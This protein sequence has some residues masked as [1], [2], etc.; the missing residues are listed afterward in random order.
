MIHKTEAD[1][2]SFMNTLDLT[3]TPFSRRGSW[4]SLSCP[5][6][7]EFQPL[8]EGLYFRTH[9]SRP[10]VNR[11]LFKLELFE[12]NQVI[13]F[14]CE[15][16]PACVSLRDAEGR[17]RL[18]LVFEHPDTLR[19]QGDCGV[20]FLSATS[21][22]SARVNAAHFS[23]WEETDTRVTVNARPSLRKYGFEVLSGSMELDAPWNGELVEKADVIFR[24]DNSGQLDAAIDEYWST[25]VVPERKPFET[26]LQDIETGFTA[27]AEGF[28]EVPEE[29]AD[30]AA[31]AQYVL[32]SCTMGAS[33]FLKREAIYM[34]LNWMDQIWSWDNCF[35]LCGVAPSDPDL[36]F[37][38]LMTMADQQ[39]EHGCYPDG[40][41]DGFRHYNYCKPPVQAILLEWAEARNP[42][43]L[44]ETRSK[45]AYETVSRVT[46]WWLTH[47]RK[48]DSALCFC[49]HGNDLGWDNGAMMREGAPLAPPDVNVFL[50][51]QCE[52][53][54]KEAAKL[55]KAEEQAE[56]LREADALLNAV[57]EE[58]WTGEQF[59]A[60]HLR[61]G[62]FVTSH[63][64]PVCIPALLGDRLP[65][66]M[67]QG[68]LKSVHKLITPHGFASE[69]PDSPHY[70]PEGYW[71]GPVW[72][73]IV[74]LMVIGL[75]KLGEQ[76]LA[77]DIAQGFCACCRQEGMYENFEAESGKGLVDPAYTWTAAVFLEMVDYLIHP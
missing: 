30:T 39:D 28:R 35:N 40:V 22:S 44:N 72:P 60:L 31:L 61:T 17:T 23:A 73:P 27:F 42:G 38:Q 63:S 5:Q 68:L 2:P 59:A 53:L 69:S 58:M 3:Q 76:E 12:G 33:G 7:E 65:E 19:L 47:R 29:W 34:S 57:L 26:A 24:P 25:W 54:A 4:M 75:E 67:K 77:R 37:D 8:G 15:A 66:E 10:M 62:N 14:T 6:K 41:N 64:H 70:E 20:R 9:H 45:E 18:K 50:V 36:A 32:W 46:R 16:T 1:V 43:F 56:W 11:E 51:L 48:K 55:G 52:F 13:P 21:G 49:Y 71:R 74:M